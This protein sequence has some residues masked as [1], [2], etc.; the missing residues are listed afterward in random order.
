MKKLNATLFVFFIFKTV[1]SQ[2]YTV[3]GYVENINTGERIIGAYVNDSI[4]RNITQTNNYG[5][6]I[7]KNL[8]QKVAIRSTYLGLKSQVTY[9]SVR[10]D[11]IINIRMKPELELKEVIVESSVYKHEANAPLGLVTIPI[12]QLVSMPALGESDLL[13]SIQNQP[14]VKGGIEGSAGIFVRGGGSG[15]NLFILDD[16]PLYNVSHLYGFLSIFNSDIVK[17]IKLMKGCFPA[18]YGGR[19]SSVLDVR[20]RDGN[21]QSLQGEVSLGIISSSFNLEGP[22]FNKNTTFILSGRRSYFDLYSA[23]LKRTGL[24]DKD[25][26]GYFFYDL[27]ARLTHTFSQNDKIYMNIYNGRDHIR[28]NNES[29]VTKGIGQTLNEHLNETSGWGNQV[30]SLRWNH[31]FGSSIFSN[32][33]L[34][35]SRYDYF[36]L[37]KY[38]GILYDS[39]LDE[40]LNKNYRANY[41]SGISDIIVKTD[42]DYSLSNHQI[43][44]LGTGYILHTFRPGESYYSMI[45]EELKEKTDTSYLNR[46]IH[47]GE[48]YLYVEDEIK[49]T[50]KLL[51]NFGLRL[52]GFTSG[53]EGYLNPEPRIS[54]NYSFSP[55]FVFKIGYSRMVQYLQLLSTSGLT[56]PTDLWVPAS[57]GVKPLR[58]GQVNA[59][60]SY[61]WHGIGLITVEAYRKW[62]IN[63]TDFRNGASLVTD[64]SPW[65]EKVTQG[66]GNAKGVEA[67]FEKQEGRFTGSI[68]YTLS[69][70]DRKY[71]ELNYGKTFPFRYHRLHDFNI[72]L[73]YLVSKKWDISAIWSYGTGYPVTLPI[74]QYASSIQLL[75]NFVYYYPSINNYRLP[76]YHRLDIGI[77]YKTTGRLGENYL[78]FDLFN[79]Y[80]RKNVINIY[81]YN[82]GFKYSYLLPIIP[83]LSY[84][85][86][87]K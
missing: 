3:S 5:F 1:F 44:L 49:A 65:Y 25:F 15:E 61:D 32:T 53:S 63:T 27:N 13:K 46:F 31:T 68:N 41:K 6:F 51:M 43:L 58:S 57:D 66:H 22:L 34:A 69:A 12:K 4:T 86:K 8:N 19:V 18:R 80:D 85:L 75:H 16:V 35:V 45:D 40:T 59:G 50:E 62:L 87:F 73:N 9:L 83:S 21:N 36:T 74:E 33:T 70:S 17:D 79:A 78:S 20:S 56:M 60:F 84:K 77:H 67:S 37:N 24:L 10:H 47:A 42:F 38:N 48:F 26:P 55:R 7:L 81:V 82:Q 14:G 52:S 30:A 64:S 76:D 39:L 54:A 2:V 72:S 11:T 28:N 71:T 29:V 23:S